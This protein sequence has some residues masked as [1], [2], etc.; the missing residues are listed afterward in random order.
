MQSAPSNQ[1]TLHTTPDFHLADDPNSSADKPVYF[2][3]RV[4]EHGIDEIIGYAQFVQI[5]LGIG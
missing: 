5:I 2:C 1:K 4:F 3:G